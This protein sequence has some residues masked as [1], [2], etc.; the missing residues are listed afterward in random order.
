M[1]GDLLRPSFGNVAVPA[2]FF[3]CIDV[4]LNRGVAHRQFKNIVPRGDKVSRAL[5]SLECSNRREKATSEEG[6]APIASFRDADRPAPGSR[7]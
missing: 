1:P 4:D 2:Q 7:L 6:K 5:V 3:P